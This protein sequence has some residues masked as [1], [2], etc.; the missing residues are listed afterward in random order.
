LSGVLFQ[1][2]VVDR[3]AILNIMSIFAASG[4]MLLDGSLAGFITSAATAIGGPIIEVGLLST[5]Q[6]SGYHYT[7][8]GELG[9]FP[10]W[11]APVYFFGGPAVGN[12]ARGVWRALEKEP[13]EQRQSLPGCKVC[14]D[15]RCVPCPNCDGVGTYLATGNRTVTCTSCRGRGFVVCRSCF[16]SYDEDPNDIDGI[17]ELMRKM[18]D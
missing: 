7:D 18:P 6:S 14:N 13:D 17:R 5:L 8:S 15:T 16:G 3:T 9:F 2:G 11:I 12:L 10:L 4:F 1:S